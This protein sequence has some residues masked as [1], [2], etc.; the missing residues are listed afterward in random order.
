MEGDIE[1]ERILKHGKLHLKQLVKRTGRH[2]FPP[3]DVYGDVIEGQATA[4]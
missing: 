2:L 4:L 3:Y 1:C